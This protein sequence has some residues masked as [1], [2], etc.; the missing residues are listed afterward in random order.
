MGPV[1]RAAPF[2]LHSKDCP[3]HFWGIVNVDVLPRRPF[4][5][6]ATVD[7]GRRMT[8]LSVGIGYVQEF[9]IVKLYN[10]QGNRHAKSGPYERNSAYRI[11]QG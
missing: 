3:P 6:A 11:P 1:T 8:V 7:N 9:A 4:R 10:S 5:I 2:P